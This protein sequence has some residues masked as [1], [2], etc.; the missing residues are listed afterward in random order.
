[1]SITIY[2]FLTTHPYPKHYVE[3][4]P[5][6]MTFYYAKDTHARAQEKERERE[7]ERGRG[8]D[9]HREREYTYFSNFFQISAKWF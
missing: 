8:R 9:T 3:Q 7:R 6:G 1:M 4:W 2:F 5:H